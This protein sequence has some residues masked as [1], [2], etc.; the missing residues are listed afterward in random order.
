MDP[1]SWLITRKMLLG[2]EV[3]TEGAGRVNE[4][5]VVAGKRAVGGRVAGG[6]G[7]DGGDPGGLA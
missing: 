5:G 3:R 1:F 4:E 7:S 6:I 2:L